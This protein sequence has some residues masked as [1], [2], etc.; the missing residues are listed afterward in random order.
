LAAFKADVGVS[1]EKTMGRST[2]SRAGEKG[3]SVRQNSSQGM[4]WL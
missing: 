4:T 1:A 2:G 3:G